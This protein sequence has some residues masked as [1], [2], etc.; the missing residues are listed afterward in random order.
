[1]FP[2]DFPSLDRIQIFLAEKDRIIHAPRVYNYLKRN[3]VP[4]IMF[5]G[6]GHADALLVH[7]KEQDR[8][9]QAI[10]KDV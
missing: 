6:Y 4:A 7:T 2:K 3:N 9:I 8:M 1:M 10:I 5:E